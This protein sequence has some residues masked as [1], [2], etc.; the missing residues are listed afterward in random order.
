MAK[1]KYVTDKDYSVQSFI[2]G[3]SV[4]HQYFSLSIDGVLIAKTGYA[5]DGMSVVPDSPA[6]KIPSLFHDV[7]Y[8][9]MRLELLPRKERSK[10]DKLFYDLCKLYGMNRIIST[11]LYIGVVLFGAHYTYKENTK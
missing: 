6:G 2:F 5:W 4:D 3:Y 8:Q 11:L 10:S 7:L 1:Y 9:M